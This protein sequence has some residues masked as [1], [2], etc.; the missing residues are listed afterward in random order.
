M[1][2]PATDALP[3]VHLNG[4]IIPAQKAVVSVFDRS[5][6]LGDGIFETLRIV[7]GWPIQW[8]AHWRRLS[9]SAKSLGFKIP[10]SEKQCFHALLQLV[11]KNR[12]TEAVARLHLSRGVGPRGYSHQLARQ[13]TFVISLHPAPRL[14]PTDPPR[15]IKV[16]VFSHRIWEGHVLQRHK[17]ANRL[18]NAIA[19]TEAEARDLDDLL[20]LDQNER[21]LEAISSNLFWFR[22]KTLVTS[23]LDA[24]ILPGTT[25]F[26]IIRIARRLGIPILEKTSPLGPIEKSNGAFLSVS[27][28]GLLEIASLE[29]KELARNPITAK[30][31]AELVKSWLEESIRG[32]RRNKEHK[33]VDA[34]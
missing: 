10:V 1:S 30:L 33:P 26:Q 13:P 24:P 23:P 20:I 3:W 4:R 25:R 9:L 6:Q 29:G 32:N 17:T 31:H 8:P 19:K 16:G 5:F 14:D 7:N 12:Q 11:Q 21:V 27:T 18:L 22:Q 28:R 2:A 34:P 15:T